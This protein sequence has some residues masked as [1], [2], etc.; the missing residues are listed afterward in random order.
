MGKEGKRTIITWRDAIKL[1]LG[2]AIGIIT[3]IVVIYI[4]AKYDNHYERNE[5]INTRTETWKNRLYSSDSKETLVVS[6]I[7]ADDYETFGSDSIGIFKKDEKFGY[8]N[9]NTK[10]VVIPA[11]YENAWKFSDGL[12]G[13]IKEGYLGFVNLD[14]KTVIEFNHAYHKSRLY[15]FIFQW[16]YCAVPNKEGLCGII[17]KEG[18]WIVEPLYELADVS[19][20]EYAIVNVKDGFSI[21]VDYSGNILNQYVIDDVERLYY[22]ENGKINAIDENGQIWT[23]YYKY[24]VNSNAGLMDAD[25]HFVTDPIY[26]NVIAINDNIF[27]ATLKDGISVVVI[28]SKGNIVNK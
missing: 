17:D 19:C 1:G 9:V 23:N 3:S 24:R 16:G 12:A 28:D 22:T 7:V 26:N 15:E 5:S 13:V 27:L 6:G 21:Q 4:F 14:N 25:G 2:I 10:Q 11:M 20:R 8:Y 18:K